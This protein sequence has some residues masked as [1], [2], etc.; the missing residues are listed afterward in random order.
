MAQYINLIS[1]TNAATP[2]DIWEPSGPYIEQHI[3]HQYAVGF[4]HNFG[5]DKNSLEVE[6]YFKTCK[7]RLDYIDGADLVGNR[8]I[9]KVLLSGKTEAYGIEFL[10]RKNTGKLNGWVAYTLS[11]SMQQTQ[12]RT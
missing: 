4:F 8:A 7:N 10:F 12:G 2:V 5:F 3:A 9:E 6:S 1:N 11:K